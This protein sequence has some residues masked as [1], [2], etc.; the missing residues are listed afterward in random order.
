MNVTINIPTSL[1][2]VTL[3]RYQKF[4]KTAEQSTD[5]EL[6][7]YKM[8]ECFC[9]ISL[10]QVSQM[11]FTDLLD[12]VDRFTK[13]LDEK[14]DLKRTFI[15]NGVEFG[16]IPNLEK[17]KTCEYIDIETNIASWETM[18][19]A[20]AVLY[21]PIKEK[22]KD[23]YIIEEYISSTTYA[24]VMK[25]APMDVVMGAN[26]FFC[27]LGTELLDALVDYLEKQ[28]KKMKTNLASGVSS[29]ENGDGTDIFMESLREMLQN[30]MKL[31]RWNYTDFLHSL[32]S[33]NKKMKLN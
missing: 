4:I 13:I 10:E 25:F 27:N 9:N 22:D 21:R 24:D 2:D 14:A 33:R 31:Y 8:I 6:I 23:R 7:S 18:H 29:I 32:H 15:L 28:T 12:L 11:K 1:N 19:K 26:V 16:F 17:I 3:Q 30:S 5:E 20:M